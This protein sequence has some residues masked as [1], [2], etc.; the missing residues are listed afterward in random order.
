MI[1][2][3]VESGP[4]ATIGYLIYCPETMKGVI[5]D[6]PLDS[7]NYFIEIA[8]QKNIEISSVF[9]THTHWDH[10]ADASKLVKSTKAKLYVNKSDEY[11][12]IEPMKY[13]LMPLP[14]ELE[15][16]QPDYYF[17]D[18]QIITIGNIEFEVRFTP[19]HTEGGTSFIVHKEKKAFV[20]DTLFNGSIGRVDLP[21]GSYEI[22][23]KSI[24][25]RL[26]TLSDDYEV[27]SGHGPK[28]TIGF[29]KLT[30]PFFNED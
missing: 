26:L 8:T 10:T 24:K 13:S 16:I 5:I 28:T 19:G 12:I 20:G 6:V 1:T 9:L 23:L 27:Y 7:C 2:Y 22:I 15:S 29:E 18:N 4:F 3:P 30:N 25:E 17:E 14:F 21:G 11:R